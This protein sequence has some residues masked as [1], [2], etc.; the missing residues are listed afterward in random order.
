MVAR[1]VGQTRGG[2]VGMAVSTVASRGVG[3]VSGGGR[4]TRSERVSGRAALTIAF[5]ERS[6]W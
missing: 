5:D 4:T 3:V 6:A 1:Q 2:L